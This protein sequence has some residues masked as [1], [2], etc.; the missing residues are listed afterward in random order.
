[1]KGLRSFCFEQSNRQVCKVRFD[2]PMGSDHRTA[3]PRV[4]RRLRTSRDDRNNGYSKCLAYLD[5]KD[6]AHEIQPTGGT[7]CLFNQLKTL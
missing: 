1:M 2:V 5:A 7:W 6:L 3:S 4:R